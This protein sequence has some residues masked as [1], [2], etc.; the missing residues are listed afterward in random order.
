MKPSISPKKNPNPDQR[1]VQEALQSSLP[2][3]HHIPGQGQQHPGLHH[4]LDQGQQHGAD[5]AQWNFERL[6]Q[7]ISLDKF[8]EEK[9]N[10][11]DDQLILVDNFSDLQILPE[12]NQMQATI[13]GYCNE[14][15][16]TMKI[17]MKEYTIRTNDLLIIFP[18]QWTSLVQ[19]DRFNCSFI[20]MK[21]E[22][23]IQLLEQIQDIFNLFLFV[24][25]NP[26]IHL[27]EN[28]VYLIKE[29]RKVLMKK[30]QQKENRFYKNIISHL[31]LSMLYEI[32]N[33]S[34]RFLEDDTHRQAKSR[35]D[36]YAERFFYTL[37]RFYKQQR[38]VQFYASQLNITAKYL[39]SI[40][41][42]T[43]GRY[44]TEWIE[45]FVISEAKNL[46]KNTSMSIQQ[47]SNELNFST[48]S[49]FG[50]YFKEHI[51]L[52]PKEFRAQVR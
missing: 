21:P 12:Y 23:S 11:I 7:S 50:K 3:Q 25:E 13:I 46:L 40:I 44:A 36:K 52:S 43:T 28:E 31:L 48:Q 30:I 16:C 37:S 15:S 41:K 42:E 5:P 9:A 38:S 45:E 10:I 1:P 8:W 34:Q 2:G 49:F 6:R 24:R 35:K 29:Y 19:A 33:F 26:C 17:N 47:I 18:G 27:E 14:G 22:L 39:S 32:C 4:T 51:H 20:I